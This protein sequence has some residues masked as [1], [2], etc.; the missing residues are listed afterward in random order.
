MPDPLGSGTA[1]HNF[2]FVFEVITEAVATTIDTIT[3]PINVGGIVSITTTGLGSLTSASTI[4]GTAVSSASAPGGDGTLTC[5]GFVDG[6]VRPAMGSAIVIATDGVLSTDGTSVEL[7]T[8]SG[9]RYV[10][11]SGIIYNSYSLASAFPLVVEGDQVHIE[12]PEL[13]TLEESLN[14]VDFPDGVYV[15]WWRSADTGV[16][17]QATITISPG[18]VVN[19]GLTAVGL[20]LVGLTQVGLTAV[21]L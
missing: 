15:A 1:S 14:L 8:M 19:R 4:A 10:N 5:W 11:A 17:T 13:A 21:G 16:M 6:E 12:T 9:S 7:T 20:T 18:G 2:D 3:D